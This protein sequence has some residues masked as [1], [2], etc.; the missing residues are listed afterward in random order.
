MKEY[1]KDKWCEVCDYKMFYYDDTHTIGICE[2]CG[3]TEYIPIP[4]SVCGEPPCICESEGKWAAH[5]MNCDNTTGEKGTYDPIYGSKSMAILG[6]NLKNLKLS[7][8]KK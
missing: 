3:N 1:I 7:E 2:H 6:W 8:R 4:C 5:C